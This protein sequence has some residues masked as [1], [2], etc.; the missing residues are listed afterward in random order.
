MRS[1]KA[2]Y[3]DVRGVFKAKQDE[4]QEPDFLDEDP[5]KIVEFAVQKAKEQPVLFYGKSSVYAT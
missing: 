1:K 5:K 2:R 3:L 4:D